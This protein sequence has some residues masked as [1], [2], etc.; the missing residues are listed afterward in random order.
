MLPRMPANG[1]SVSA[2]VQIEIDRNGH[3][4][5]FKIVRT[6]GNP[7]LDHAVRKL[8]RRADPLPPP[9]PPPNGLPDL[10]LSFVITIGYYEK[11]E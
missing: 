3:I 5:Y 10:P 6:S 7:D 8:M 9:P 4:V 11:P 2:D 1:E